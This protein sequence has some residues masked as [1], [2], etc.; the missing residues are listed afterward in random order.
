MKKVEPSRLYLHPGEWASHLWNAMASVSSYT[1]HIKSRLWMSY[2]QNSQPESLR[3]CVW[4]T[5][6]VNK[7]QMLNLKFL[8]IIKLCVDK[9]KA[10]RRQVYTLCPFCNPAL[11]I[12]GLAI[13]CHTWYKA[14]RSIQAWLNFKSDTL[15]K[16]VPRT[17]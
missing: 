16:S 15:I 9:T 2:R 5:L 11:S 13:G 7:K 4:K 3:N 12:L 1:K 10:I 8:K 14:S 17:F 6:W